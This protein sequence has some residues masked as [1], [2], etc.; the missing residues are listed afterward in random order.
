MGQHSV[1]RSGE[2]Q[3]GDQKKFGQNEATLSNNAPVPTGGHVL[4]FGGRN[5]GLIRD[6]LTTESQEFLS[7]QRAFGRIDLVVNNPDIRNVMVAISRKRNDVIKRRS[8][9][10]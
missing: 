8:L 1:Q 2:Q 4:P 6:N 9:W 3:F 5:R 7:G 10:G